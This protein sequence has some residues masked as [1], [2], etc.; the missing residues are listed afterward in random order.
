MNLNAKLKLKII[1]LFTANGGLPIATIANLY[2]KSAGQIEA[3]LREALI[4]YQ[5]RGRGA[6]PSIEPTLPLQGVEQGGD[7]SEKP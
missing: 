6:G 4:A 7:G 2:D 5:Q 1:D 3:V